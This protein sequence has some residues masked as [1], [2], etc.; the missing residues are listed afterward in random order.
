VGVAWCASFKWS[1]KF[2]ECVADG[3]G[4]S[5]A[6]QACMRRLVLHAA[7]TVQKTSCCAG[8][9]I[10]SK[11]GV[12]TADGRPAEC[13]GGAI[14]GKRSFIIN[15]QLQA[16]VAGG[17]QQSSQHQWKGGWSGGASLRRWVLL[18]LA[19]MQDSPCM[20]AKCHGVA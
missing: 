19:V 7:A 16:H 2:F 1:Y 4:F 8:N 18:Q 20:A 12:V 14:G 5:K 9:G 3:V 17:E 6:Q 10:L 15:V 13:A 11:C